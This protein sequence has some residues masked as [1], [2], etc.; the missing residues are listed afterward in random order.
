M[1]VEILVNGKGFYV[2]DVNLKI[3]FFINLFLIVFYMVVLGFFIF[4]VIDIFSI[5]IKY[6]LGVIDYMNYEDKGRVIFLVD[7]ELLVEF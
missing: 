5:D 7:G 4:F 2:I 6:L 1:G 3:L